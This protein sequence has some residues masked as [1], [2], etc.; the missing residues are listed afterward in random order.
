MP[1]RPAC[2]R[3]T[4][5]AR[6]SR[7]TCRLAARVSVPNSAATPAVSRSR[8]GCAPSSAK[9]VAPA[10]GRCRTDQE[11]TVPMAVARSPTS[12]RSTPCPDSSATSSPSGR[13]SCPAACAA[14]TRRAS[15]KPSHRSTSCRAASSASSTLL[16]RCARSSAIP[17]AAGSGRSS[18]RWAPG[19][20]CSP[21][22]SVRLVITTKHVELPGR[23]SRVW[24]ASR[25]LSSRISIRRPESSL[26]NRAARSCGSSGIS[27]SATP[28]LRRNPASTSAGSRGSI[29]E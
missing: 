14:T 4:R 13:A 29:G 20:T 22:R 11:N 16:P 6:T 1:K 12:S 5:W 3:C 10:S 17:S 19:S 2:V 26:R 25:A 27:L 9:C 15:G 21:A 18:S 24:S 8:T 28:R 23:S 7:S